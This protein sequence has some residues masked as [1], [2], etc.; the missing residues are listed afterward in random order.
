MI[1]RGV[2]YGPALI[3]MDEPT[4][5]LDMVSIGLLE[6]A[7]AEYAGALLLVSHDERFLSALTRQG[8]TVTS[9]LNGSTL[10]VEFAC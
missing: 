3:V 10:H 9:L 1:A 8:W 6:A 4:N 5:H 7:L 2:F